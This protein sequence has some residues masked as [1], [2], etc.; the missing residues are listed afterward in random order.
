M[1]PKIKNPIELVGGP[2]DGEQRS[3]WPPREPLY[4]FLGDGPSAA[5]PSGPVRRIC[6]VPTARLTRE[7]RQVFVPG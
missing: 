4:C 5:I 3:D 6:Y 1:M 7:G 2:R